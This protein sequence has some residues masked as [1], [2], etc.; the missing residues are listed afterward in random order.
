[1]TSSIQL[2]TWANDLA[3]AAKT[4]SDH[5]PGDGT[6]STPNLAITNV[7]PGKAD[8]ARRNILSIANRLQTQL[9]EPVEFIQHLA[10]QNQLL[11]CLKWLGEFQVL[12]CIPLSGS[13]PVKEVADMV[14][15]PETQLCRVV[16]MT[17]TAGFLHEPRPGHIAHTA[18][19][20]SF[21][22]N[23]S[24]LDATMFL[25]ETAAPAALHM[26]TAT[27]RQGHL[28]S[29]SDTAYSIAFNTSQPFLSACAERTRLQ[30]QWSAYHRCAGDMD[31]SVTELLGRLSWRSLGSACV[32]DVCAPS[33]E[34]AMALAE[35]YP[36]LHFI[37]QMIEPPQNSNGTVGTGKA[38][39]LSR[40]ITVQKRLPAAI[41]VVKD[42]AV[43][44]LRLTLPSPTSPTQILGEL[45]AHLGMLRGNASATLILAP[46][47]LPEPGT[48]DP[49]V[50]AMARL[51]DLSRLQLTNE[52]GLELDKLTEI[53]NSVHDSKGQLVVVNQLR[54]RNNAT[55]ALGVR[56]QPFTDDS[57]NQ[58][59]RDAESN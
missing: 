44:I 59:A 17:A 53:I 29:S 37:V 49:D 2:E 27:Q 5:C 21:V 45:K 42:A 8:R 36:A 14:V 58:T 32:V 33:T 39:G 6:A 20:A 26:A 7:A 46:P 9:A 4:L 54:S 56:Y 15:A 40:R 11:A 23:L 3:I 35:M 24:F 50:E 38:E 19:S 16:R 55:T 25:A 31:D 28:E 52:C 10:S 41:Q 34:A 51:G 12:A 47:L 1:M 30:R 43:Y 13:I 48:V 57:A 18:L 22:T